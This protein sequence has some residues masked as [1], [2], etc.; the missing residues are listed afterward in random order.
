MTTLPISNLV[1]FAVIPIMKNYSSSV[2]GVTP[3]PI[4]TVSGWTGSPRGLGTA[5]DVKPNVRWVRPLTQ[6]TDRHALR[7]DGAVEP[8]LNSGEPKTETR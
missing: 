7:N 5:P 3:R 4:P 1:P 8:E 6:K 2:T